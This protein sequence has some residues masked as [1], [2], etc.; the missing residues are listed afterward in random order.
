MT[1][2]PLRR[3]RRSK[4]SSSNLEPVSK[5]PMVMKRAPIRMGVTNTWATLANPITMVKV[6]KTVVTTPTK[7]PIE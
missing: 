5:T 7:M 3:F 1:Q 6:M 2:D 4:G